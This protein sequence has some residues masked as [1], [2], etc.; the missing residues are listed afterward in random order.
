MTNDK[1]VI[2]R[3]PLR[4][5]F[6]GGGTDM[7]YFYKKNNGATISCAI[8]YYI[9]VTV[10]FHNNYSEKYRLNYSETEIVNSLEKIKNLRVKFA[11]KKLK[12]K[13]PL[14]I[15]TFADLPANAGLGSS[16]SFTVGLLKALA[17][18]NNQFFSSNQLAEMAYEIEAKITNNSLGKQDHYIASYGGLCYIKYLKNDIFISPINLNRIEIDK[19][20]KSTCLI[21]T[22][23]NR[24]A[25]SVLHDQKQR[26]IKNFINLKKIN[27]LTEEFRNEIKKKKINIK[28][29]AQIINQSWKIKKSFSKFITNKNINKLY[30]NLLNYGSYGGKLLGAG[31]GG[32]ILS[33]SPQS[34]INKIKKKINKNKIFNFKIE[35]T[36]SIFL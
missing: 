4:I 12:I 25:D 30:N 8:N 28:K 35:Q 32:F 17:K 7:P 20:E 2:T 21:W 36:G 1:I 13:K 34:T 31:N 9:Y 29:I 27:I 5:S 26:F 10:K 6:I 19:L 16:S 33:L 11:I 22:G 23:K 18:L 3:T 15:N 24:S 14:Y